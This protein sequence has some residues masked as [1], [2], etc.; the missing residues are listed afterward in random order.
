MALHDMCTCISHLGDVI[1]HKLHEFDEAI[2]VVSCWSCFM[3]N[4]TIHSVCVC[5]L[6]FVFTNNI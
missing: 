4:S 3:C 1:M 5:V 6:A 2:V